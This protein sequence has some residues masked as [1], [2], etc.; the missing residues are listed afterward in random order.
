MNKLRKMREP[1]YWRLSIGQT[2]SITATDEL[3][4]QW[5][6][7]EYICSENVLA[8]CLPQTA[9]LVREYISLRKRLTKRLLATEDRSAESDSIL[10]DIE[11]LEDDYR[12]Q[13]EAT[14]SAELKVICDEQDG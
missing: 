8:H 6:V 12:S 9:K 11:E 13:V 1:R 10:D 3:G 14:Q 4:L 5:W 2:G 7:G